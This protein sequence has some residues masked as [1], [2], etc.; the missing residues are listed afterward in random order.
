LI[1]SP[2]SLRG[3]SSYSSVARDCWSRYTEIG[4]VGR[5]LRVVIATGSQVD[6]RRG[7][8]PVVTYVRPPGTD[9]S[10]CS[11]EG[12]GGIEYIRQSRRT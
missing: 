4:P 5:S 6:I 2:T 7:I 9:I 12:T 1:R 11:L 3:R 8:W 10:Y